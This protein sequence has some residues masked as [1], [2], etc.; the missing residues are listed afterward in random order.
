MLQKCLLFDKNS[1]VWTAKKLVLDRLA[2]DL[3]DKMNWGL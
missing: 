2:A 3:T 1:T